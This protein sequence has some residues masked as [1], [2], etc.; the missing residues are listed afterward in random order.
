MYIR[1]HDLNPVYWDFFSENWRKL[2]INKKTI[3]QYTLDLRKILGVAKKFLKSRVYCN[4][5]TLMLLLFFI[6]NIKNLHQ[7]SEKNLNKRAL[8][9][10]VWYTNHFL[11]WNA[12]SQNFII[13]LL[14][15]WEDENYWSKRTPFF[16]K[17]QRP[18]LIQFS[19]F[20]NFLWVCWFLRK[21]LSNF[22]PLVW[23]LHKTYCL[24]RLKRAHV[25]MLGAGALFIASI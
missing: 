22:V 17:L 15:E 3:I 20:N 9:H 13:H 5:L 8:N 12:T 7:F 10:V 11:H 16:G 19:K 18:P 4:G 25:L 14:G 21:N 2:L 23:K 6:N 1:Q 24:K